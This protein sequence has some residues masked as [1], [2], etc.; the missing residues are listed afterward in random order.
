MS[1][2]YNT[3]LSYNNILKIMILNLCGQSFKKVLIWPSIEG[4]KEKAEYGR[5]GLNWSYLS[6]IQKD[7][8]NTFQVFYS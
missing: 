2:H 7:L 6:L 1:Y 3:N 5:K 4:F 8:K